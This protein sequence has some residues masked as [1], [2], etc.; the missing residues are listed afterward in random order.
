MYYKTPKYHRLMKVFDELTAIAMAKV[1]EAVIRLEKNPSTSTDTQSV[2]EKLLKIDRDVA[3]VMSFDMVLA[4][5]DTVRK[6]KSPLNSVTVTTQSNLQ[7]TSAIVGILFCLAKYP[8][9]QTKL[10]EE[11]RSILPKKDSPLTPDSMHNLPYLRACIKEGIRLFP[12]VGGNFRATGKD[13]VLQGYRIPKGVRSVAFS[14]NHNQT[15]HSYFFRRT[16][17]WVPW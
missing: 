10:R 17:P 6:Q 7:T 14:N 1:D 9:K 5:V 12:P 13:I 15:K 8:E 3:I 16:S 4:G 11:L 2:L